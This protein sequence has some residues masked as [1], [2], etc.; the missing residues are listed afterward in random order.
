[1]NATYRIVKGIEARKGSID[2]PATYCNTERTIAKVLQIAKVCVDLFIC[3]IR[4]AKQEISRDASDK[5][6]EDDDKITVHI[7]ACFP[8]MRSVKSSDQ[9]RMK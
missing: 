1:M 4:K 6:D 2:C 7:C 3:L 8:R 9:C 5:D